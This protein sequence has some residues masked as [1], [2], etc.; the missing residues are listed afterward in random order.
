MDA[1]S[2]TGLDPEWLAERSSD[3]RF[4]VDL[5][6]PTHL[7]VWPGHFPN[8]FVVPGVLQIDWVI[9]I[10]ASRFNIGAPRGIENLKFKAPLLPL[11]LF[12]LSLEMNRGGRGIEFR[13]GH[14]GSVFSVGRLDLAPGPA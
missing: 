14:G 12:T 6:V 3:G 2:R 8:H 1:P 4:E 7:D 13:L 10:A 11:Q 5:R 9:R